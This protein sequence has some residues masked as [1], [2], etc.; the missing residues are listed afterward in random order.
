MR[1]KTSVPVQTISN[2]PNI[3]PLQTIYHTNTAKG[4]IC[5]PQHN[6]RQPVVVS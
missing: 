6:P 4:H 1:F 3:A 5:F 2:I